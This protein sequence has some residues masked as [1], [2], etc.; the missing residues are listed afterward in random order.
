[1]AAWFSKE[2]RSDEAQYFK[3]SGEAEMP[4]A[5]LPLPYHYHYLAATTVAVTTS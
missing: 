3:S 5:V 1:M 4:M 2:F